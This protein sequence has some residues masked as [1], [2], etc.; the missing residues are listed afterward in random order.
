MGELGSHE[1][2]TDMIRSSIVGCGVAA[3]CWEAP[4]EEPGW[5][6]E[7]DKSCDTVRGLGLLRLENRLAGCC[8]CCCCGCCCVDWPKSDEPPKPVC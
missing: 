4:N 8:C 3:A 5:F 1:S 6:V 7:V 2:L